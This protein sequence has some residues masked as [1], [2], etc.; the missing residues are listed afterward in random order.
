MSI[1]D[2]NIYI[3][4][5]SKYPEI[6]EGFKKTFI[7]T[8]SKFKNLKLCIENREEYGAGIINKRIN[9]ARKLDAELFGVF[10]DDMWFAENWLESVLPYFVEKIYCIS[11]GY[12]E[13]ISKEKFDKAVEK[14]KDE[15][16]YVQYLYGPNAIFRMDT[17]RKI[18]VFDERFDWTCDDLDW[19]W[20]FQLNKLNSI[21]LKKITTAHWHGQTRVQDM[22][23][24]N[25]IST[26][27]KNRFYKKHGYEAYRIIRQGYKDN[28]QYFRE[29]K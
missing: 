2:K 14:T 29:F 6:L 3:V 22:K 18:G 17:F 28:H 11:P 1:Y 8:T 21:T 15:A 20:R 16:F 26:L 10:N 19:A 12:V 13:T 24:W 9:D 27:N 25:V 23:A 5:Q 7:P 4:V